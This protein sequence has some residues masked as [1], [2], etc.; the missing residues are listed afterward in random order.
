MQYAHVDTTLLNTGGEQDVDGE[1]AVYDTNTSI[2]A[3]IGDEVLL[4]LLKEE[5]SG[6]GY[7][8]KKNGFANAPLLVD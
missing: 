1:E 6:V 8:F 4:S 2:E 3:I 5:K 7:L